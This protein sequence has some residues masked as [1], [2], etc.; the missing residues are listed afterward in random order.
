MRKLCVKT[1]E[2][3]DVGRIKANLKKQT[4]MILIPFGLTLHEKGK[5]A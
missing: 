1:M 2:N 5:R 3:G 4:V